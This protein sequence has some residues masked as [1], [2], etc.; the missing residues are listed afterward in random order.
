MLSRD[1]STRSPQ[2]KALLVALASAIDLRTSEASDY[3][4]RLVLRTVRAA[5]MNALVPLRLS[6]QPSGG[7]H[8]EQAERDLSVRY[9][10]VL[11][12]PPSC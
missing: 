3:S 12:A 8:R 4:V 11:N 5:L 1:K 6:R 7:V 2:A 9:P 10:S